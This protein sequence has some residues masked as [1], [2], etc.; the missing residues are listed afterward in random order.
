VID[1]YN[2][3]FDFRYGTRTVASSLFEYIHIRDL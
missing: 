3:Q 2:Q 1:E